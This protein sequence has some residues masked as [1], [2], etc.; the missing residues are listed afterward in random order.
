ML[1]PDVDDTPDPDAFRAIYQALDASTTGRLG[2][3]RARLLIL[4]LR[5]EHG[6]VTG[7]L[8]G[9]TLFR[10]LSIEMLF[11][12]DALRGQGIGSRLIASAETE[13]K[14]R[15]CIGAVVD[16]FSFQAESFYSRLGYS[17]F[18]ILDDYPPGHRRIYLQ[19]HFYLQTH[20][21]HEKHLYLQTHGGPSA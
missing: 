17:V 20:F 2:P 12:P 19:K 11:V 5:N 1:L 13:A 21:Y 15:G 4:P 8:W 7:G 14:A 10:W 16:T 9:H 3:A 18:G 6:A